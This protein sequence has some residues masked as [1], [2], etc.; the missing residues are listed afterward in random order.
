[1]SEDRGRATSRVLST[2]PVV[3]LERIFLAFP[4]I[5]SRGQPGTY[6]HTQSESPKGPSSTILTNLP[7]CL[8]GKPLVPLLP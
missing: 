8:E 4:S 5:V 1:M 6:K 2:I 7:T 3:S